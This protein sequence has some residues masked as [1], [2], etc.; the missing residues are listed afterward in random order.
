[1]E[2][3]GHQIWTWPNCEMCLMPV[4]VPNILW[5]KQCHYSTLLLRLDL[6]CWFHPYSSATLIPF[7]CCFHFSLDLH[8]SKIW[9]SDRR[10]STALIYKHV[11][12]HLPLPLTKLKANWMQSLSTLNFSLGLVFLNFWTCKILLFFFHDMQQCM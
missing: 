9:V 11:L 4:L 2:G 3:K 7:A 6:M 12:F 10:R 1:M 5:L 8:V